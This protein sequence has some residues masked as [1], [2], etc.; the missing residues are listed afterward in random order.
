MSDNAADYLK[1]GCFA[2]EWNNDIIAAIPS[3]RASQRAKLRDVILFS[4]P[5]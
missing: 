1:N 4:I 3:S 5:R 2:N